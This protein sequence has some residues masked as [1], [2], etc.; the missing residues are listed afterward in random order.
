MHGYRHSVQ[1]TT[2]AA[3]LCF[4]EARQVRKKKEAEAFGDTLHVQSS[5]HSAQE[6]LSERLAF[7][8]IKEMKK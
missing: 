7:I 1:V 3:T 6:K 8:R 4:A 5:T 2:K